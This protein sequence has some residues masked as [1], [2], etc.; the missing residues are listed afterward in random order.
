MSTYTQILYHIV[1]ST[2]NRKRCLSELH[3]E[4]L[5]KYIWGVIN[6][7]DCHLYRINGIED[8]IHFATSLRPSISLSDFVKDIKVSSSL[9][10]KKEKIFPYFET[11]QEGYA[12]F[13]YSYRDRDIL[14]DYI[15]NQSKHHRK[16][17]FKE[18]LRKLFVDLGVKFD[19]RY[20]V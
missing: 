2:R 18:E 6:N 3:C 16:T 9:W 8:H 14:I 4:D 17:T 19:E 12:A 10:I 7:K 13:T 1:F 15:K 5:Y 11:W 20:L